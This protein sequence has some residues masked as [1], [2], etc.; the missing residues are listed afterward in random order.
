[1]DT[2]RFFLNADEDIEHTDLPPGTLLLDYLR[3]HK[4]LVGTKEGCREGDCGACAVLLG[5]WNGDEIT[6]K[7]ACSCLLVLGAVEGKHVVTIE[8]LHGDGL[9]PVQKA[10]VEEGATQC[11]FCTPGIVVSL[12]GYLLNTDSLDKERI[13]SAVDGNICRCIGYMSIKRAASRLCDEM[14]NL[15]FVGRQGPYA[16]LEWLVQNSFLPNYFLE[17]P[18]RLQRFKVGVGKK[19]LSSRTVMRIAGGTDILIQHPDKIAAAEPDLLADRED[20]AGIRMENNTCVVGASVTVDDI[21]RSPVIKRLFPRIGEYFSL[22]SSTPIRSQATV[23]GNLVNASPIGDLI[24]F[25]LALDAS[26]NLLNGGK[27]RSV[28]LKE[29]YQGY[30]KLDMAEN[31]LVHSLS[32]PQP[33][34]TFLFNFEKVSK[35]R[36]LD[37]ASVNSAIQIRMDQNVIAQA[38]L[39]AGGVAPIPLYLIRTSQFL[40]GKQVEPGVIK[41]TAELAGE[42]ISPIS[43]VRGSAEYK[44]LLLKQLIFSHFNELFPELSLAEVL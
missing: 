17:I 35:R 19:S 42:E 44:K 1:M 22:I 18:S 27:Q 14:K 24:V 15:H 20:L 23:A 39:S 43:D 2:I 11:G 41:E 5:S 13:L 33:Q 31:E 7:V 4:K 37:I 25:F 29:F 6:Y 38:H 32:F 9:S 26:V 3:Q 21:M 34:G 28:L 36:N 12:T 16:R 40:I 10:I 8:G 30:K